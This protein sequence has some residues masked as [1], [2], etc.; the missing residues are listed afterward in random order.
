M[1]NKTLI[2]ISRKQEIIF[3]LLLSD[4][5]NE[6]TFS[7]LEKALNL[8]NP[9]PD[10]RQFLKELVEEEILIFSSKLINGYNLYKVNFKKLKSL[11]ESS[12]LGGYFKQYF[13]NKIP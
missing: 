6:F 12:E 4:K 7:D 9:Q 2:P 8:N 5:K 3:Y 11:F 10:L 1:N 13:W